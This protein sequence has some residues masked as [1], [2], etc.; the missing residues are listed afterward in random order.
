[1]T[2]EQREAATARMRERGVDPNAPG[3]R[4]GGPGSGGAGATGRSGQSAARGGA[5]AAGQPQAAGGAST[6]D[7]LFAPL[8]RTESVG[9][10]FVYADKQL[11]PVRLRLGITDGQNT[12]IVDG[13]LQEGAGVVTNVVLPGQASTRPATTAFPGFGPQR[14][15]F[16][17]GFG[18][19]RGR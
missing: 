13:D 1:M 8:P 16:G 4:G 19:G 18:G 11:K 17:G 9:R 12:E 2:P 14:G 5:P 7:A 3:G 10:V 15:G 6:I